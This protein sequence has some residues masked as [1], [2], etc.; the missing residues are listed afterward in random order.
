MRFQ[1]S[2]CHIA[3]RLQLRLADGKSLLCKA[4]GYRAGCGLR[5]REA[6]P[7]FSPREPLS[8]IRRRQDGVRAA[9]TLCGEHRR[10][11]S[12]LSKTLMRVQALQQNLSYNKLQGRF[13]GNRRTVIFSPAT[14]GDITHDED[15]NH[16]VSGGPGCT[17]RR[18]AQ[19]THLSPAQGRQRKPR[20]VPKS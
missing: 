1:V 20:N 4:A 18:T 15:R 13:R 5:A 14:G 19:N 2:R 11:L 3:A 17:C 6:C 10:R 8:R 16:A 9:D 7:S 12:S